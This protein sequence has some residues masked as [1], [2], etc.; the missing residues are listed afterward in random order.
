MSLTGT[1]IIVV[2]N[3]EIYD[4]WMNDTFYELLW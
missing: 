2:F 1:N 3:A 4:S